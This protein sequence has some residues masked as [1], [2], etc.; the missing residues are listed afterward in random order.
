M[1]QEFTCA[2]VNLLTTF[3]FYVDP[4]V[5]LLYLMSITTVIHGIVGIPTMSRDSFYALGDLSRNVKKWMRI[6]V[7]FWIARIG[8][9]LHVPRVMKMV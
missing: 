4:N 1:C 7:L 6:T 2:P 9:S 5:D 8:P 3:N